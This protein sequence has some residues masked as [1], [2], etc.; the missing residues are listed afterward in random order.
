MI[1]NN[2]QNRLFRLFD[3]NRGN[4]PDALEEDT[5]PTL[6]RYFKLLGRKFWKLVS[7]NLLM[8]PMILPLLLAAYFYLSMDMTPTAGTPLFSALYGANLIDPTTSS[9][10][11]LDVFGTQI[12]VPVYMQTTT[13]V[14]I[15]VAIAFLLITFGWQNVGATYILRSMVRGEPVF[16]FSD[17]FYA[18]KRNFKQGFLLGLLDCL[19]I[20]LLL[21]DFMYFSSMGGSF[22]LDVG[23]FAIVALVI[24]YFFMRF[25]IYLMLV[26]FELPIRKILKNALIFTILGFKRNIMALLGMVLVTAI[27]IAL[28]AVFAMTPL[29]FAIPLILPF[30]YYLSVNA[31]TAAYAAYP[32]IDRYMIEPYR[33]AEDEEEFADGTEETE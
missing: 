1:N 11:L 12:Q 7:L 4:R 2:K 32:I 9:V 21:F 15:G 31:F 27:N 13:Y 26:T 8:L 18:I 6:K 3:F 29:S 23:Y 33:G 19:A 25:Y 30:F 14:L 16:L 10:S 24:L 28:F 20:F 5:T 17:Y 22:W